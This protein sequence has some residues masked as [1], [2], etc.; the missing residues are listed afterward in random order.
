MHDGNHITALR[1]NDTT[2]GHNWNVGNL[3]VI[4]AL[5]VNTAQ[6]LK[7][8]TDVLTS[9]AT[10]G[11]TIHKRSMRAAMQGRGN[12]VSVSD[13]NQAICLALDSNIRRFLRT[14]IMALLDQGQHF[15][16]VGCGK[17]DPL[18]FVHVRLVLVAL[19]NKGVPELVRSKVT[20]SGGGG[21]AGAGGTESSKSKPLTS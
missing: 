6:G 9:N 10:I 13:I 2:S 7:D 11:T 12:L 8:D 21:V 3:V 18:G 14:W 17:S 16:N 20:A 5:Y 4:K 19:V 1:F 15:T